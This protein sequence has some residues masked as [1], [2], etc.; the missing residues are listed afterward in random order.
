[1]RLICWLSLIKTYVAL[2]LNEATHNEPK[3]R[4]ALR[5]R[6]RCAVYDLRNYRQETEYGTYLEGVA[7][8]NQR[9]LHTKESC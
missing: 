5:I 4:H 9:L 3:A 7:T 2:S 8:G 1:M 6:S